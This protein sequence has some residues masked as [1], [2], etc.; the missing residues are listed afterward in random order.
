MDV[1]FILLRPDEHF[2]IIYPMLKDW[3]ADMVELQQLVNTVE[4]KEEFLEFLV[5]RLEQAKPTVLLTWSDLSKAL[6]QIN[7]HP[8]PNSES[9]LWRSS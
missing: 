7:P 5:T 6:I 2:R 1:F 8:V 9:S 3:S 4:E